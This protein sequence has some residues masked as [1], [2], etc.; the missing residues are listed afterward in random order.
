[1]PH[2][3]WTAD[4]KAGDAGQ[5]GLPDPVSPWARL[6]PFRAETRFASLAVHVLPALDSH[7]GCAVFRRSFRMTGPAA[8]NVDILSHEAQH[9][10]ANSVQIIASLLQHSL[11]DAATAEARLE[12]EAAYQRIMAVAALQRMLCQTKGTVALAPYLEGIGQRVGQSFLAE[13]GNVA[14]RIVCDQITM[15]ASTATSIGLVVIELLT[16]AIK[17]AFPA[18]RGGSICVTFRQQAAEWTLSVCDDGVGNSGGSRQG[19][20][21]RIVTA[22][23]LQLDADLSERPTGQ[24]TCLVLSRRVDGT[25]RV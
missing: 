1:M 3:S 16:N 11:R 13:G 9:R 23:A 10:L 25:C 19:L 18:Q 6:R 2:L 12:I 14:I 8:E 4:G 17:H 22:L 5:P 24:G 21:N 15:E 20:G 7:A